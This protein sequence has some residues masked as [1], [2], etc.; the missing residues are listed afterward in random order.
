MMQKHELLAEVDVLL[1]GRGAEEVFIGEIST[2]AGN[3]LERATDIIKSMI[4][5]YGM[6]DVA[7]L[8]VLEKQRNTFLQGGTTKDYSEKMA[9]NVDQYTKELLD[10]RYKD[11][12]KTLQTYKGA[13][14]TMVEQ[15][16]ETETLEGKQVVKIIKQY[17]QD[18]NLQSRLSNSED[19]NEDL[20]K[21]KEKK[22]KRNE[23]L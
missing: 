16:F 13:I 3:D 7:G 2:G 23:S 18:N 9:E 8:M 11:V 6:S 17:E 15:L 10:H 12:L 5:L 20:K 22:D 19:E 1:G 4:G 21:A 14:E